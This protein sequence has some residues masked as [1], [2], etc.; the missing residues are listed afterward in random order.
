MDKAAV[1]QASRQ[2]VELRVVTDFHEVRDAK[3][4]VIATRTMARVAR[5]TGNSEARAKVRNRL[6]KLMVRP[7]QGRVEGRLNGTLSL[8]FG[9]RGK[10]GRYPTAAHGESTR[11]NCAGSLAHGWFHAF[12]NWQTK[13]GAK[14]SDVSIT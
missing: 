11:L 10:G 12:D 2:N 4:N 13:Y 1:L 14:D 8:A 6:V 7:E 3:G 5:V 9:V